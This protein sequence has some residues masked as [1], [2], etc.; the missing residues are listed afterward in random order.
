MGSDGKIIKT[1]EFEA[2]IDSMIVLPPEKSKVLL[3]LAKAHKLALIDLV[4]Q[5]VCE[6]PFNYINIDRMCF[7]RKLYFFKESN[8][9]CL[10]DYANLE[11][12]SR[13]TYF[14]LEGLTQ[15]ASLHT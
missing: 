2:V 13:I 12:L 3:T 10:H 9:V 7:V 8:L 4:S 5:K 6:I 1:F 15:V 11:G 14:P